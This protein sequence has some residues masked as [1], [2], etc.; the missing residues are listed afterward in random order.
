[1]FAYNTNGT[2]TAYGTVSAGDPS[3]PVACT[4]RPISG[5][6]CNWRF[7]YAD[8]AKTLTFYGATLLTS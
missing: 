3:T 6:Q 8:I 2:V 5:R 7:V 1:V 4:G